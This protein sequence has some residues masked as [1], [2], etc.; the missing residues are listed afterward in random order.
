MSNTDPTLE[1]TLDE[2][3]SDEMNWSISTVWDT[4]Y[5]IKLGGYRT[6]LTTRVQHVV[7][8]GPALRRMADELHPD[9]D[10]PKDEVLLSQPKR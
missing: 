7:E 10:S 2:L 4:G 6:G 5:E 9:T 8:I 1:E 3:H